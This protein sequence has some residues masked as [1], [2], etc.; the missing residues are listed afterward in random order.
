M[1][2]QFNLKRSRDPGDGLLASC[3]KQPRRSLLSMLERV[4]LGR[5]QH[6]SNT[7]HGDGPNGAGGACHFPGIRSLTV[8]CSVKRRL[9]DRL[10]DSSSR[11]LS[12]RPDPTSPP[13]VKPPRRTAP[14]PSLSSCLGASSGGYPTLLLTPIRNERSMNTRDHH[15]KGHPAL[16]QTFRSRIGSPRIVSPN[17][18]SR[19]TFLKYAVMQSIQSAPPSMSPPFLSLIHI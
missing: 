5:S 4:S 3:P 6:P 11:R 1:T 17:P 15:P 18:T 16:A 2:D 8:P 14:S 7:T 19:L 12:P 10:T 13:N 9:F